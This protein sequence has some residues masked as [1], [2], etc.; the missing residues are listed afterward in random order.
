MA[1]RQRK[2]KSTR[3]SKRR[4]SSPRWGRLL[5]ILCFWSLIAAI[6][7]VG[8]LDFRVR[9]EFEG[10]RW[11]LPAR[12]YSQP[13][14]LYQSMPLQPAQLTAYLRQTGYSWA[15]LDKP[16]SYQVHGNQIDIHTRHFDFWDGPQPGQHIVLTFSGNYLATL[17]HAESGRT[18]SLFRLEPASIGSFYPTHHE[19]RILVRLDEVPPVL[20]K[21]LLVT[22]DRNYYEHYGISIKSIA[23]AL[24]AN[25]RAGAT[26]QGG[27]TLTQQLVKNFFLTDERSLWRKINEAIMALLLEYHYDKNEILEAYLN[28]IYLGQDGSRA[29]HGFG[30]ASHFYFGKPAQELELQESALLVALVRGASFYNPHRH[31]KRALQRRNL[32]I[33]QMAEQGVMTSTQARVLSRRPLGITPAA[34]TSASRYPAFLD[35]V[36]R[37]LR[38]DYAD[39]DLTSEG[40]RIFS[41]LDLMLQEHAQ[42]RFVATLERLDH[43][44]RHGLNGAII[45][46][47]PVNGE[48]L[49]VIGGR[50][51]QEAGFNRALDALRPVGSLVKPAVYL[52]ALSQG[53]G[54]YTAATMLD[55]SPLTIENH[56]GSQWQPRNYDKQYHGQVP[57]YEALVHSYNIPTVRL[58]MAV[59]VRK[60]IDTLRRLG[61]ARSTH[62]YPSLFL[63]AE[64]FS[65]VEITQMYQTLA[66]SGFRTPLRSIREVADNRG[67]PLQRYPLDVVEAAPADAVYIVNRMLQ[68][69]V[70]RGTAR[71]LAGR[72]P[73][74]LGIAGKTGTTDDLRDSWFAGY[75]GDVLTVAW[76][77]RDDNKPAGFTGATGAMQAWADIMDGLPLQPLLLTA[78]ANVEM[79]WVDI[80][81]GL[82]GSANCEN[83][84]E[85]PFRKGTGPEKY[86][87]CAGGAVRDVIDDLF[88]W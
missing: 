67:Q 46:A 74:E 81:S 5:L 60:V 54:S 32:I 12:V 65:P 15:S 6:I 62:P 73:H 36:R 14:E 37:Q 70:Q 85:Y 61:L 75:S 30:L 24:L 55:D 44:G 7:Y 20:V 56:D 10:K 35:L 64:E 25:I 21:A 69:V 82:R 59:G 16:G 68:Q 26:V 52:T 57:L 51:P 77:G 33:Q 3:K 27:S 2:K 47:N 4:T 43:G 19:D 8:Y 63:G 45:M 76:L 22:E 9:H 79:L 49:S 29:I 17:K 42:R 72:F 58:G 88:N 13:L 66:A 34:H 53:N 1:T 38:R 23:R 87:S 41:T 40:L 78:P 71:Q 48:V 80:P 39:D 86:A 83:A 84:V 11:S 18:L 31:G 28:E 50:R